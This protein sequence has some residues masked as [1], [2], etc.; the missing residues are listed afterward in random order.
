MDIIDLTSPALTLARAEGKQLEHCEDTRKVYLVRL[1]R[2]RLFSAIGNLQ[3]SSDDVDTL[4]LVKV[5]EEKEQTSTSSRQ[6]RQPPSS[7]SFHLRWLISGEKTM[8]VQKI[9][10][11]TQFALKPGQAY[12]SAA[13]H[14]HIDPPRPGPFLEVFASLSPKHP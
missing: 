11:H 1:I 8:M 7:D 10:R 2:A 4:E 14:N 5:K 6:E 13:T 3:L 12:S 9:D